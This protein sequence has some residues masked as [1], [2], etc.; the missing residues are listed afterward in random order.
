[1]AFVT[2]IAKQ[3]VPDRVA[4]RNINAFYP[5]SKT[6]VLKVGCHQAKGPPKSPDGIALFLSAVTGNS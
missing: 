2:G 3:I 1:M 6:R 5:I 4:Y